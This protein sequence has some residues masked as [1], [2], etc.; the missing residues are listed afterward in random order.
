[1]PLL[2]A[3][4]MGLSLSMLAN[5]VPLAGSTLKYDVTVSVSQS[6]AAPGQTL[7]FDIAVRRNESTFGEPVQ[8][9]LLKPSTGA[10]PIDVHPD[11]QRSGWHRG[12][13]A[14]TQAAPPGLYVIHS[15]TGSRDHPSGLGHATFLVGGIVGDFLIVSALNQ[16]RAATDLD[17]YLDDF[18]RLGGNFLIAHNL[19]ADGKAL[20]PCGVCKRKGPPTPATDLVE[21]LL[22]QADKRGYPVLLSVGWDM[23][24]DGPYEGRMG[25]TL[26]I[27]DDL[28]DH[29]ARHP[30]FGGFYAYQEGSGTYYVSYIREFGRHAKR[31]GRNLLVACAPYADDPLLAGYLSALVDLDMIIWQ[32]AVMASYRPDNRKEYPVRRVRDFGSLAAGAKQLQ[33]KIALTHVEL[34]GYLEQQL[35]PG[36]AATGYKNI[37]QQILSAATV[38]GSDGIT[39]FSYHHHIFNGLKEHAEVRESRNAVLDGLKAFHAIASGISRD[40][41]HLALYF[42]YSDFVVER[43]SDSFLPALDAFRA[44]GVPVDVLPYAPPAAESLLP[45][46]PI[47]MNRQV[48]AR[49]LRERTALVLPDVSGLQQTD[50]D[51]VKAF[52]EQGGAVLAFGQRIPMGRSYERRELFGAAPLENR[53]HRAIIVR[54]VSGRMRTGARYGLSPIRS[55]SWTAA[56]GKL[57]ATF[58]DGSGAVIANSY[59]K[60]LAVMVALDARTAVH[61][62]PDLV[63]AVVDYALA[64]TGVQRAVNVNGTN[65]RTDIAI[66]QTPDTVAVAV[67]NYNSEDIEITIRP[68]GIHPDGRP[69]RRPLRARVP[70]GGFRMIKL[71]TME[72]NS[73]QAR[74]PVSPGNAIHTRMFN[75]Q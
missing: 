62:C 59:G 36:I 15:W 48:L 74:S 3:V 2:E 1:M 41:N 51:L 6:R 53:P 8:A 35:A 55:A 66:A 75:E 26:A 70:A 64:S 30:S 67:V 33:G 47:H 54:D 22:A 43:W 46:Y 4:R 29:Y 72:E 56:G 24:W 57:L 18:H 68:I 63:R 27:M 16:A 52:V 61:C 40:R 17:A 23:T 10:E 14:L 39:L 31:L 73:S 38:S 7:S 32:S 71:A 12:V 20:F 45:Y 44:L 42:P 69:P 58:E 60:G 19:I 13:I 34:F 25:E 49:L 21:M 11:P 37:Y 5:A 9:S 28:Y 65:E 50:S